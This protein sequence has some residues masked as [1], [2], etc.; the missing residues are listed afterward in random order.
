[1]KRKARIFFIISLAVL[2]AMV[3]NGCSKEPAGAEY[4]FRDGKL[5]KEFQLKV[6]KGG[7]FDYAMA[8]VN[9]FFKDVG[10]IT[11]YLGP[12]KGGT[13]V[14][15]AVKGDVDLMNSGHVINVAMARQA[16]M[17][18]KIVMQGLVDHPDHDKGHM[19]WLVRTAGKINA[20]QDLIGKKIAVANMGGCAE[21]LTYEY[22]RQNGIAK[23]QVTL[24]T[25]PDL[26]QE[27]ALR[28]GLID[29]AFLHSQ[30]SLAAQ[31]RPGLKVLASSY[32]V[33]VAAGDGE[34]VG[35]GVRAFSEE[36][37][38]K[39]PGVV[40]AYIVG[41]YRGQQ[42]GNQHFE[43]AKQVWA[44]YNKTPLSGGNWHAQDKWVDERKVQFW[45]D[46]MERNGL[47]KPGEIKAA[48]LY[49]NEVNP[50]YTGELK[51]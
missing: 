24:V 2:A 17:K 32:Q 43:E 28:Q 11:D 23:D 19:Y 31:Q 12:I 38:Q 49:T 8:D 36:F 6:V 5:T 15:A 50:F 13:L 42:W 3:F 16:G 30:F 14:Q 21:L 20:P 47:A 7:A 34:A 1:M 18:I 40:K 46:M 33:G 35:L 25:M 22:L 26:Q 27:Q 10:I 44:D 51:E 29:V 37:I 41:N 4:Q 39:Y 45:I 48:D 9:G